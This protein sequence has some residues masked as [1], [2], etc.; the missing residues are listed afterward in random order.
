MSRVGNK[1]RRRIDVERRMLIRNSMFLII[2]LVFGLLFMYNSSIMPTGFVSVT[3]EFSYRDNVS[4]WVNESYS[5]E[6]AIGNYGSLKSVRLDG[7]ASKDFVGRVYL[8]SDG[9]SYLVLDSS[10]FESEGIGSVTGLAVVIGNVTSSEN[11]TVELTDDKQIM[12]DVIGGGRKSLDEVFRF[13]LSSEF[14][15]DV[16]H[17]KLCTRWIVNNTGVCYGSSDCCALVS[18]EGSGSWNDSFYLSYGRYGSGLNNSVKAQVIYANYSVSVDDAYSDIWYSDVDSTLAEFYEARIEFSDLCLETCLLGGFN[19]SSYVLRF[20]VSSG[21]LE[22]D[23]VRYGVERE[24]NVSEVNVSVNV[25]EEI[26]KPKVVINKPVKWVKKVNVSEMVVNLTVNISSDALNVSVRDVGRNIVISKDKVKVNDSGVVK[27]ADE[28]K[29]SKKEEKVK[30]RGVRSVAVEK[31][32]EKKDIEVIIEE[33]VEAIEVEYYTSGPTSDEELISRGKRVVVSSDVHYEDILAY[34][35]L[36]D[37]SRSSIKLYWIV[38][39][40]RERVG[41]DGYDQDSDGFIDYIEWVVPSLS[42]QTYEVILITKAEHLD[43]NRSFISDIYDYVY[44]LDGNYSP[45]IDDREYVRV[46]FE[47]PLDNTRD[48]TIYARSNSSASIEVYTEDSSDLVATFDNVSSEGEYN[49]YM[50]G[51]NGSYDVFDLRS[52]GSVEYDYIVDPK[53]GVSGNISF[54]DP[55]PANASTQTEDYVEVNVSINANISELK[56]NWNG[57]NYT[58]FNDSLVLMFN[59]DNVSSLGE[60]TSGS[61]N[62]TVDVSGNDNNGTI[63]GPAW[64]SSGRFGGAFDFDGADDYINVTENKGLD[65]DR[66]SIEFWFRP[67]VDYNSST[68]FVSFIYHENYEIFIRNGSMVFGYE[69]NNLSSSTNSWSKGTWYHVMATYD[70]STQLLYITG[71][72]EASALVSAPFSIMSNDNERVASFFS[73]GDIIL[74][75]SI[76]TGSCEHP[77]DNAFIVQDSS[78]DTVAYVNSTGDLCTEDSDSSYSSVNCDTPGDGSFIVKDSSDVIVSYINSTGDLCLRGTLT[79]NGSP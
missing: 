36:D 61:G 7:S 19:D 53:I 62:K 59:F 13:N 75:G 35:Y 57:T 47:V 40:S 68:N 42:N 14:N 32:E 60:Q 65:A 27:S 63:Y 1:G 2:A 4:L 23:G 11:F 52:V 71:A 43:V 29:V 39:E 38:N 28:F 17:S 6:W 78:G 73:S 10:R 51:L 56:F 31:K 33:A 48:I 30:K 8:E 50:T 55:T 21:N 26:V 74:Q 18:L 44:A 64:N 45:V 25:S 54:V 46:T 3:S 76:S 15:W 16:D 58:Y 24:V 20:E 69:S 79:E 12:I 34:T 77:G 67:A 49:V 5:Y 37:V 72:D 22:V 41:F 66:L 70:G 9:D